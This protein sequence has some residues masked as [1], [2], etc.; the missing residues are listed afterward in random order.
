MP[1]ALIH[2]D[3]QFE[4]KASY[5]Q[6]LPTLPSL[7]PTQGQTLV[8]TQLQT[9]HQNLGLAITSVEGTPG[10]QYKPEGVLISMNKTKQDSRLHSCW[11]CMCHIFHDSQHK[12]VP[13]QQCCS[14]GT[15]RQQEMVAP[16]TAAKALW[17]LKERLGSHMRSRG[18]H[19]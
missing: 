7:L 9:G 17:L 12:P 4:C 2:H 15:D 16:V 10:L 13:R 18:T 1:H 5:R 8:Y 19:F 14:L 3:T 11:S 6:L